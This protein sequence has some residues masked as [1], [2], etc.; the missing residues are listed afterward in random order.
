M[1]KIQWWSPIFIKIKPSVLIC[2]CTPF[3]E[4][5]VPFTNCIWM[6]NRY[7]CFDEVS[8]L[9]GSFLPPPPWSYLLLNHHLTSLPPSRPDRPDPTKPQPPPDRPRPQPGPSS[10][11]GSH[12]P[13]TRWSD[14]IRSAPTR[15]NL[16]WHKKRWVSWIFGSL[17]PKLARKG[18]FLGGYPA[19]YEGLRLTLGFDPIRNA[20]TDVRTQTR[21]KKQDRKSI[22]VSFFWVS[23]SFGS[24]APKKG[25]FGGVSSHVWG[26]EANPWF[27][28]TQKRIHRRKDANQGEKT[29]P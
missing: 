23:W 10:A 16:V 2:E 13:S 24:L 12:A 26:S 15:K 11:E 17:A 14:P 19:M 29:G 5:F 22:L 4:K 18:V 25:F 27:W 20:S 3:L 7:R 1:C 21:A 6:K 9:P 28:P 8:G